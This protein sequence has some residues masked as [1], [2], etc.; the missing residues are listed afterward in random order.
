MI[1]SIPTFSY[2]TQTTFHDFTQTSFF[3][4]F[5]NLGR[6]LFEIIQTSIAQGG[7]WSH[8]CSE[9]E[10]EEREK[11]REEGR[12]RGEEGGDE[13]GDERGE[14]EGEKGGEEEG[15]EEEREERGTVKERIDWWLVIG[16]FKFFNL[17]KI[18]EK[19]LTK[20]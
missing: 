6:P 18:L 3:F 10:E 15:E 2:K 17:K 7:W 20:I 1:F 19:N 8:C 11:E 13:R 4:F 14:E 5:Y 9:E 12:E 16:K